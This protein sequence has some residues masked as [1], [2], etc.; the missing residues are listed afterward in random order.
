MPHHPAAP[1]PVPGDGH[2]TPPYPEPRPDPRVGHP[3]PVPAPRPAGSPNGYNPG[4]PFPPPRP[5]APMP[6]TGST[7]GG[8]VR[9]ETAP[10]P[11]AKT[12]LSPTKVLAGA[13]AS[14]T[15]ALLGSYF[16]AD[17][18]VVGAAFGSVAST[19]AATFYQRSL[20]RTRDTLVARVRRSRAGSADAA[21]EADPEMTIRL[22]PIGADGSVEPV[23]DEPAPRGRRWALWAGLTVLAFAVAMAA[24]TGIEL[25]KGSTIAGNEGTSVGRVVE[26]PPAAPEEEEESGSTGTD[27]DATETPEPTADPDSS[28][29]ATPDPDA[30]GGAEGDSDTQQDEEQAPE[31]DPGG[32]VDIR[33]TERDAPSGTPATPR[34]GA[35]TTGS[36]GGAA[37]GLS[38][39][40]GSAAGDRFG[41]IGATTTAPRTTR[42]VATASAQ[43]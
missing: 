37:P 35:G 33:P 7:E 18:T 10:A 43:G 4:G 24:I 32:S 17:G 23:L 26:R 30:P 14:V 12:E 11:P 8:T 39:R 25:A 13:G 2:R 1:R 34:N 3:G 22:P 20:D 19:V 38:N 40:F 27:S 41:D 29:T 36:G 28:T 21:A 16:G 9:V 42:P 15:S 5:P 6:P 31:D